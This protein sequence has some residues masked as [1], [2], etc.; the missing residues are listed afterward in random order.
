MSASV[1]D[2]AAVNLNQ[3]KTL[4]ANGLST[5]SIKGKPGFSNG[6]KI[7]PDFNLLSYESDNITSKLILSHFLLILYLK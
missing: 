3:I 7:L 4:L 2:V 6:S 1:T 5:F